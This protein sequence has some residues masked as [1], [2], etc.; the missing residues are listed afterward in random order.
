MMLI[1][2]LLVLVI[3][4]KRVVAKIEYKYSIFWVKYVAITNIRGNLVVLIK[5]IILI[6]F[7]G[8]INETESILI[9]NQMDYDDSFE[10]LNLKSAWSHDVF[11]AQEP[12]CNPINTS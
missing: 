1:V 7:K 6:Y 10:Y 2:I 9:P 5:Y 3:Q 12:V 11:V 8:Q 4:V